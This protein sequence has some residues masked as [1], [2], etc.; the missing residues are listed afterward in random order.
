MR[1]RRTRRAREQLRPPGAHKL[2]CGAIA[3]GA[4]QPGD[5]ISFCQVMHVSR[6]VTV[7]VSMNE[8]SV[9][10]GVLVNFRQSRDGLGSRDDGR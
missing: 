7:H 10:V 8:I 1:P 6:A 4:I 5:R 2:I 3:K 9:A